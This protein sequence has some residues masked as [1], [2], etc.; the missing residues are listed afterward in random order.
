MHSKWKTGMILSP[1]G[2]L[3]QFS[4]S[5]ATNPMVKVK[6]GSVLFGQKSGYVIGIILISSCK[7]NFEKVSSKLI[8]YR[9]K[10]TRIVATV[11]CFR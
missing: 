9:Q 2:S 8:L 1:A 11:L 3:A 4:A 5:L 10:C 6:T 7:T